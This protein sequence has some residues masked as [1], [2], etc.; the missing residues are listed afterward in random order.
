VT[1]EI[2]FPLLR[3]LA[4]CFRDDFESGKQDVILLFAYNGTGKTRLSIETK[5]IG[6]RAGGHDT[7]YYNAYTEDLFFWDNDLENDANYYLNFN[8]D[9]HF[10][11]DDLEGLALEPKIDEYLQCYADFDFKIDYEKYRI[12]FSRT[13]LIRQRGAQADSEII[14]DNIKISRG[15]ETLFIWCFFLAI[16]SLALDKETRGS[17]VSQTDYSWVK[18][19]YI[20]DPVSSLD[21]NNAIAMARDLAKLIKQQ[22]GNDKVKFI[23]SSHHSLFFNV[24]W[25][26]LHD[27]RFK[28]AKLNCKTYFCRKQC[29]G[30]PQAYF[31]QNTDETPF[32]Y[33]L[34]V[35]T[36][37]KSAAATGKIYTYHFNM[38]RSVMEKTA[39]FFNLD[40]FSACLGEW[41]DKALYARA[42]NLLS[43]GK[44]SFYEPAEMIEDTKQL[45]KNVLDVF[46]QKY[47]FKL[48][49]IGD[50]THD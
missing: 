24:M 6:K 15:E 44:Y 17:A 34:S 27:T 23:I 18:Y 26:E 36:E 8:S 45:F 2:H 35:L 14:E 49:T 13:L 7:L 4:A 16:C 10:F 50:E 1:K 43:H 46:L 37:L 41:E 20:D 12:S 9:S 42:L 22:E 25:N 48:P 3:K 30:E 38:L 39:A 5:N 21:E 32:A 31:L 29:K 11:P 28:D 47:P 40:N 33:H 19:I